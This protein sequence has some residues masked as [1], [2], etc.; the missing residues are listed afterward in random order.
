L[1]KHDLEVVGGIKIRTN[2]IRLEKCDIN[3]S[4]V[5]KSVIILRLLNI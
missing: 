4:K 3:H 2:N 5:E 1:E